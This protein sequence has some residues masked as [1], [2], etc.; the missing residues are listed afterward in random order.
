MS[1][2]RQS[3][4]GTRTSG[5]GAAGTVFDAG[6][7]EPVVVGVVKNMGGHW[8]MGTLRCAGA[9]DHTPPFVALGCDDCGA[10]KVVGRLQAAWP[11][12]EDDFRHRVATDAEFRFERP[13]W[14]SLA[15]RF[16]SQR[17]R[18][19]K[20]PDRPRPASGSTGGQRTVR[21]SD[22]LPSDDRHARR[23]AELVFLTKQPYSRELGNRPAHMLATKS[24]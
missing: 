6:F 4:R 16:G 22:C 7:S 3:K 21:R 24:P 8:L 11:V 20:G 14:S 15:V 12:R 17:D 1:Y 23:E 13:L 9:H 10:M 19:V 18:E 2:G 5:N